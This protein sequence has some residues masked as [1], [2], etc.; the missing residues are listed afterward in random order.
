MVY[1]FLIRLIYID[2]CIHTYSYKY[3]HLLVC[4]WNWGRM[5]CLSVFWIIRKTVHHSL[6]RL[7]LCKM[8]YIYVYICMYI[9]IHV[10]AWYNLWEAIE[11]KDEVSVSLLEYK[12]DG[13]PFLNQVRMTLLLLLLLLSF[14][15][16]LL[17][18]SFSI[19]IIIIFSSIFLVSVYSILV[20]IA[21]LIIFLPF[22]FL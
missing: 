9:W 16:L 8:I 14:S 12:K 5:R 4:V 18:L 19:L 20:L 17:L 11:N 22:H 2:V 21:L 6:I 3:V 1:P 7:Q 15:L 10:C 13:I